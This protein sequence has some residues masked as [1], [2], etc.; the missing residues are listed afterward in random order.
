MEKHIYK[1]TNNKYLILLLVMSLFICDIY[2]QDVKKTN[3]E[4]TISGVVYDDLGEVLPGVNIYIKNKPG[5]GWTSSENGKF[6]IKAQKKDIVIFSFIGLQDFEYDVEKSVSDLIIKMQP[7]ENMIEETVVIGMGT[8][9][10]VSVVGAVENVN[11]KDLQAPATSLNNMLGGKVAGIISMQNSGEPGKNISE[12]WVRGIG[13][14]GASSGALVL[15]DGLEGTLSQV[16]PADVESFAVLKDASA[17]AVYGVRGANGVVLITT[18]RGEE[19]KLKIT[20][21][22]NLTLSYLNKM[23]EYLDAFDYAKLANEAS[24]LSGNQPLY[25]DIQLNIIRYGLDP[26]LYPNVD[27]QKEI[28]NR[29][30]LQQT[31]YLSA[32]GGGSLARYFISLGMSNETAAYKQEE[33]SKYNK[34]VGYNTYNYRTNLDVN[35]TK[36]TTVYLGVNG[37]ISLNNKPGMANTDWLWSSQAK[38]TPLT[39]PT[40]YSNGAFPA[41]GTND[42]ISPY[43]L[44]NHTGLSTDES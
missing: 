29:T 26:D 17:T 13:T 6:T 43:I 41:F 27:W 19:Q 9:R 28:L 36:S 7:S 38:L 40:Q 16:D 2:S 25:S 30:S 24:V 42:E 5:V 44:L 12:F 4:F 37:Y 22:A 18:K 14:F 34:N 31:Y 10:K 8:Q 20:G 32:Q 3:S 23:P 15:I 35:V 1:I 11:V 33:G 21:R 39:V